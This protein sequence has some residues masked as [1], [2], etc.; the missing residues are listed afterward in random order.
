MYRRS[1]GFVYA[2]F[3]RY[4]LLTI[5]H[6]ELKMINKTKDYGHGIKQTKIYFNF[7]ID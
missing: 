5:I 7:L 3:D 4:E 6:G 1:L 2:P